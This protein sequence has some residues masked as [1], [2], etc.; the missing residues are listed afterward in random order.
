[1]IVSRTARF[2]VRRFGIVA[3]TKFRTDW[4]VASELFDMCFQGT[5]DLQRLAGD[6]D[7][8]QLAEHVLGHAGRQ[9]D[10]AV[11]VANQHAADVTT[12]QSDFI[13]NRAYDIPWFYAVHM[14]DFDAIGF[15]VFLA[16]PP[17]P[18]TRPLFVAEVTGLGTLAGSL[19]FVEDGG[20]GAF[21]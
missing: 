17:R 18:L 3:R 20:L 13:R 4:T 21:R 9:V 10:E 2:E 11:I 7:F 19:G 16:A 15:D 5:A 6:A 14:A 8:L 1:M 12:F